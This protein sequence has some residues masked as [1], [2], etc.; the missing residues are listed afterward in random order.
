MEKNPTIEKLGTKNYLKILEN[1]SDEVETKLFNE[2]RN[3]IS[4][5]GL[6]VEEED[7]GEMV[8]DVLRTAYF[9]EYPEYLL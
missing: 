5:R 1:L 8:N 7:L 6:E 4:E 2:F 3:I 9:Q